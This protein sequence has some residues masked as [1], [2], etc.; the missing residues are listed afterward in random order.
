M[1]LLILISIMIIGIIPMRAAH[2][3]SIGKIFISALQPERENIPKEAAAQLE[4]KLN[5][6]LMQNGIANDDPNNRFILTTKVSIITKDIVAGP[7]QKISMNLDFTFIIGDIEEN[8]KFESVTISS[9]GVGINENKAFISAIRNIKP[10]N[11]QLVELITAAKQRIEEYYSLRC[12]QIQIDAANEAAQHNYERAIYLL[13]QVPDVCDCAVECQNLAIQYG[14]EWMNTNAA[15]MLNQAKALWAANPDSTGAADAADILSQIPAGT[16]SQSE[17]D[18][19]IAEISGKL[20]ADQKQAWDFKMK[21][22]NDRIEKQKRDD[23]A[24]LEQQRADNIFRDK[25]QDA[26]NKYRNEQQRANN[27]YRNRQQ[28]ADNEYRRTQQL[29]NN[30]ARKQAIDAARQICLT[31]A[32]N[33]TKTSGNKHNVITW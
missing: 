14:S 26:D 8:K 33:Q 28:I 19:L 15:Q 9:A 7:P 12:S 6:L 16:S 30:E 20:K 21:Q 2:E 31:Y 29:A 1:R 17:I 4:L 24:R 13:M 3:S 32:K 22:Y 10:G 23:Q 18:N 11:P 5:Q 25:Q 27:E